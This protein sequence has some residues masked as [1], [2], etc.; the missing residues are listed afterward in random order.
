MCACTGWEKCAWGMGTTGDGS[1][2]VY[3]E[4]GG[5]M[6]DTEWAGEREGEEMVVVS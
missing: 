6:R 2:L 1:L 3:N 4:V 5:V